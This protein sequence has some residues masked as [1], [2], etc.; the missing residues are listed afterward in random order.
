MCMG[1]RNTCG[2]SSMLDP[3]ASEIHVNLSK[4]SHD[5][6]RMPVALAVQMALQYMLSSAALLG[7]LRSSARQYC[8]R[9]CMVAP[10]CLLFSQLA[11]GP[12]IPRLPLELRP[13]NQ[14]KPVVLF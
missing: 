7:Q 8:H 13:Q 2:F 9:V 4:V 10:P 11:E 1:I 3:E 6:G 14:F 5:I 12:P